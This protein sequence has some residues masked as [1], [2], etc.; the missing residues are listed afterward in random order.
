MFAGRLAQLLDEFLVVVRV[1]LQEVA[2]C[3]R[4]AAAVVGDDAGGDAVHRGAQGVGDGVVDGRGD[5]RV[6]ELEVAVVR[7]GTRRV[8]FGE[9]AGGAQQVGAAHGLVHAHGGELRHQVDRDAGAEDRGRP[10]E[11]GGRDTERL[12]PG[13]QAAAACRAVQ[14]A[15]L[16][17]GGLGRLE[18]AVLH[19]GEE[20]NGLVRVAAGHRP[21]LAAERGV[22]VLTQGGAGEAGGRVGREGAQVGD[23]AAR[24]GDR[25][26]VAGAVAAD[27][28]GAAGHHDQDVLLAEALGEGGQPAQALL[29]GP[30]GVVDQQHQRPVA[31]GQSA[32]GRHQPV[33]HTLRVGLARAGFRDAEGRSGDVVPVAEVLTRLF[34]H[35]RQ[36]GGLEQLPYD[37]EGN[38]TQGPAA[39]GGPHLA[40]A[41]LGDAACFGQ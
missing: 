1:D 41:G 40:A 37:V 17:G 28:A 39:P 8:G 15:Q 18:L 33:A 4:G 36:Q 27:L 7:L 12:Q 9:D 29:V 34:R 35:Q 16:A 20:F 3:D 10:G 21:D 2:G 26:E 30:V 11:P 23:G 13:D 24:G 6:D 14:G 5:Q 32:Y 19:L 22:G 38:G 25:V 31:P